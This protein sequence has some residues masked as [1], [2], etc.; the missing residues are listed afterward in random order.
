VALTCCLRWVVDD[1]PKIFTSGPGTES[2]RTGDLLIDGHSHFNR[3]D[4]LEL[5]HRFES[6]HLFWLEEVNPARPLEDLAAI[7]KVATMP[8]RRAVNRFTEWRGSI[9]TSERKQSIS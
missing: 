2:V 7:N 5:A 9:L 3:E 1:E 6:L 4:G 8:T